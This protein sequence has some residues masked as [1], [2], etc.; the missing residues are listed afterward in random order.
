MNH[1]LDPCWDNENKV[2]LASSIYK[3]ANSRC[4]VAS[5]KNRAT[6]EEIVQKFKDL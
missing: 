6:S 4:L 2:E 1:V 5:K 3:L